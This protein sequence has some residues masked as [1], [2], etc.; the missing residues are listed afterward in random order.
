MTFPAQLD[1]PPEITAI[2]KQLESAG[3][4]A[5]CVGGAIRD[6]LLGEPQ[7]DFD[8][9]TAATPREV[10][11]LFS[12]TVP[13]GE[14]YGT[15]GVLDRDKQLHEVTTFRRDIDT[16]GRHARVVYGVSLEEDLARRDFT[17]NAIAYHPLRKEWRDPFH[18]RSDLER[19]QVRAVGTAEERFREDY[20]RI[21][22]AI[23]FSARLD[24]AIEHAT[25]EAARGAVAGLRDLSAERVRDEWFKSI[26]TAR[27]ITRLVELW[28]SVGAAPIW[29]PEL[30]DSSVAA[31]TLERADVAPMSQRDP[32]LFTVLLC[33]DPVSVLTRLRASNAEISRAAALRAGPAEPQG[34][35]TLSVRRWLAAVAD[36]AD[37]FTVLWRLRHAAAPAWEAVAKAIRARG[38]PLARK[39][40][41]IS[42]SDL[43]AIGVR[44]GPEIG[45]LLDRLLARVI[46]NPALNTREDLL[47]LAKELM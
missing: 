12:H 42:G 24:F 32:L 40:L 9:A 26:R 30:I 38:E 28:W 7:E 18:G 33:L 11:R 2:V 27:S 21:L 36:T 8:V 41:S 3:Y 47:R 19:R 4:E 34:V 44:Q 35:D 13:V 37:D 25:W 5:W 17:I 22:R 45:N 31:Q 10:R 20:L 1:V 43:M 16:D 15:I 6:A 14:K 23:R 29:I 39:D 46:D